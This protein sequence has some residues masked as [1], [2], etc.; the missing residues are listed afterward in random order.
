MNL[1]S[2]FFTY[3]AVFTFCSSF[4]QLSDLARLDFTFIPLNGSEGIEYTK[5]RALFNIPIALEKEKD[6][7]LFLGLDYSNINLQIEDDIPFDKDQLDDF[8][9]L[10][11]SVSYTQK[12]K[13]NWRLGIRLKP[14]F[15]TNLTA[16]SLSFEDLVLSADAV[17]IKERE[18]DDIRKVRLILGVTYSENRGIPFPL[19]FVSYYKKFHKKWSFNIGIPKSNLQY[20]FSSKHRLKVYTEL[21]GFTANIQ[22][23][24]PILDGSGRVDTFNLF[25]LVSGLQYEYHF[26][27]RFELYARTAFLLIN[28][29]R[30]RDRNRD[31]IF[32][33]SNDSSLYLRTGIR[34][35]I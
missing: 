5:S 26:A 15:S 31:N 23:G 35:R 17:F 7:Y 10:D 29:T 13:N 20:H 24:M 4:A 6:R 2:K 3:F 16:S 32:E 30:L 18:I 28:N 34:L 21:D 8:Q 9:L 11:F 22:E 33:L 1:K 25:L 19:P 12:L 14:G 27:K